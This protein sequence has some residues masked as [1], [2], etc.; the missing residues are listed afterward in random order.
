MLE[1]ITGTHQDETFSSETELREFIAE[2]ID[3]VR[4][5]S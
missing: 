4:G 2:K 3:H 5:L 1:I